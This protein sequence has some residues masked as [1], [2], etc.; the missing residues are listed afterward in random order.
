M[1]RLIDLTIPYPSPRK[2]VIGEHKILEEQDS[3][4]APHINAFVGI[5]NLIIIESH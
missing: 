3:I 4:Q 5:R 1:C 2:A